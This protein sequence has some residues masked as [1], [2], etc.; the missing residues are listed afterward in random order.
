[1]NQF[2]LYTYQFAANN[3]IN[4]THVPL[5]IPNLYQINLM[6]TS[7]T[8]ISSQNTRWQ[9]LTPA[10]PSVPFRTCIIHNISSQLKWH[11]TSLNSS[12]PNKMSCCQYNRRLL[13]DLQR[14]PETAL[15]RTSKQMTPSQRPGSNNPRRPRSSHEVSKETCKVGVRA[16]C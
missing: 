6:Q 8:S 10:L 4:L 15:A 1:M 3:K 12:I 11:T 9:R 14:S 13:V 5:I 7:Q 16:N 2:R